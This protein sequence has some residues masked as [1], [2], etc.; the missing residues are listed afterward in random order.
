[1][2]S[3]RKKG[4]M[5]PGELKEFFSLF[6]SE[7]P[8]LIK[9]IMNSVFSEEAGKNMGKAAAAYYNELKSGGLP[10][11]VAVKLTEEYMRTFTSFGDMLRNAGKGGWSQRGKE[12][13]QELPGD[14]E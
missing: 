7:L 13:K 5:E 8:G 2:S 12:D 14:E 9:S 4:R 11:E 6:S 10:E 1:M 3:E